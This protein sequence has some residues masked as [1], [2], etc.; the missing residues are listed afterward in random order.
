MQQ[1]QRLENSAAF[2]AGGGGGVTEGSDQS[3][4][5]SHAVDEV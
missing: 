2:H 3:G 4:C 5:F 1:Q